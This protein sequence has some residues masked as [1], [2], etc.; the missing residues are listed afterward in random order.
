MDICG[1]R[2]EIIHLN[3]LAVIYIQGKDSRIAGHALSVLK[4]AFFSLDTM[5]AALHLKS[6]LHFCL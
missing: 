6:V 4:L 3:H 2:A 1:S 5:T